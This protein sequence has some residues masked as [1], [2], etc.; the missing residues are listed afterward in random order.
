MDWLIEWLIKR[1]VSLSLEARPDQHHALID[2][3]AGFVILIIS[4]GS[5]TFLKKLERIIFIIFQILGS[6][7]FI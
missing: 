7:I 3:V 4:S 6:L 5:K 2:F 1:F